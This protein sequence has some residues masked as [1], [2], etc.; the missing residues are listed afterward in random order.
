MISNSTC[1]KST[2]VGV[3]FCG[4]FPSVPPGAGKEEKKK[5][6]TQNTRK[7]AK[8]AEDTEEKFFCPFRVF[9]IF[10]PRVPRSS[11]GFCP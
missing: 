2:Q 7:K 3:G 8:S 1:G 9:Q 11:F 4:G 5:E 6:V 10:F